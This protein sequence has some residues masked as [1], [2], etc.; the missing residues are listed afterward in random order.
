MNRTNMWIHIGIAV[1]WITM[2]AV[3]GQIGRWR[4]ALHGPER[5]QTLRSEDELTPVK[6]K[7][8]GKPEVL[9]RFKPGVS[10]DRIRNIAS[11]NHDRLVDEI[12]S[13]SG[14]SVI[15]DLD[16]WFGDVSR[17]VLERLYRTEDGEWMSDA[18]HQLF[19]AIFV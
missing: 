8:D 16:V 9:V 15:D 14:L 10:L 13:V 3:L 19:Q 11:A 7:L 18:A 1:V 17:S 2:A 5:Q 4:V 6:T 12:E